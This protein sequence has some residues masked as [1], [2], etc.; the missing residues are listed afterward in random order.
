MGNTLIKLERLARIHMY[1]IILGNRLA[2]ASCSEIATKLYDIWN[3]SLRACG[4]LALDPILAEGFAFI[5]EFNGVMGAHV[6]F[7]RAE[8]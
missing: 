5:L 6:D 1:A 3:N 2:D 7:G 8:V 4:L